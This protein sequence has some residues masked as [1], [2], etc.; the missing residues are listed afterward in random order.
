MTTRPRFLLLVLITLTVAC[1]FP[2][3]ARSEPAGIFSDDAAKPAP[4]PTVA[5]QPKISPQEEELAGDAATEETVSETDRIREEMATLRES[6]ETLRKELEETRDAYE[7]KLADSGKK[8]IEEKKARKNLENKLEKLE[9]RLD[10]MKNRAEENRE[11]FVDIHGHFALDLALYQHG[12]SSHGEE[13][14]GHGTERQSGFLLRE[15]LLSFEKE[16]EDKL[17]I[18]LTPEYNGIHDAFE[19]RSAFLDYD[20][21]PRRHEGALHGHGKTDAPTDVH[22]KATTWTPP[23]TFGRN[24]HHHGLRNDSYL[25]VQAG[26]FDLPYGVYAATSHAP[27][28]FSVSEPLDIESLY[29]TLNDMGAMLYG[30]SKWVNYNLSLMNG[31]L[32]GLGI[33]ARVGITPLDELEIGMSYLF[34]FRDTDDRRRFQLL[35]FEAMYAV[36]RLELLAQYTWEQQKTGLDNLYHYG[37]HGE[38]RIL[39]SPLYGFLRAGGL[40]SGGAGD[41]W[42]LTPGLGWWAWPGHVTVKAEYQYNSHSEDSQG[43]IQAVGYF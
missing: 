3:S 31:R 14:D 2:V 20:I 16:F 15:V 40:H 6:I 17:R 11:R 26:K 43:L 42:R 30:S 13:E 32:E 41:S 9:T 25:A 7:E 38:V 36:W 10:E 34:E 39:F 21:F 29:G 33:G 4:T 19:I 18:H 12:E 28:R 5:A 22:P 8:R 27:Q 1:V 35:T 23:R 24:K 37:G